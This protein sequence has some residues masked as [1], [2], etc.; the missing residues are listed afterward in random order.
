MLC[1]VP[2]GLLLDHFIV[3]LAPQLAKL[4]KL[5]DLRVLHLDQTVL[6]VA[7][8]FPLIALLLRAV[9]AAAPRAIV[10]VIAANQQS[11]EISIAQLAV[12]LVLTGSH[13]VI[14]E[15]HCGNDGGVQ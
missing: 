12:W 8:L 1:F 3:S 15:F 7:H 2:R 4:V 5:L 13:R 10:A 6:T 9:A 14:S 11:I